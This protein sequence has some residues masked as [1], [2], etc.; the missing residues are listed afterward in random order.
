VGLE[1]A[2]V[3]TITHALSLERW[4]RMGC[5]AAGDVDGAGGIGADGVG[6]DVALAA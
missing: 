4:R 5:P 1:V 6:A 2:A 3:V